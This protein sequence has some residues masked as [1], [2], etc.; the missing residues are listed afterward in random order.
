MAKELHKPTHDVESPRVVLAERLFSANWRPGHSPD[1]IAEK[2]IEAAEAFE[3]V[4]KCRADLRI[5][6]TA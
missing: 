3:R 2:C 1:A 4:L 6:K 5:A